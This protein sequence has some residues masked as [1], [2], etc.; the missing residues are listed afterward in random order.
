MKIE[1]VVDVLRNLSNFN[2]DQLIQKKIN[3]TN[4]YTFEFLEVKV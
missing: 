1:F 3:I 4:L 2:S